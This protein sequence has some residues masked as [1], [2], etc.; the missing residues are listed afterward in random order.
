MNAEAIRKT[1]RDAMVKDCD[2]ICQTSER[3]ADVGGVRGNVT[4]ITATHV[5]I[6]WGTGE[7]CIPLGAIVR[8]ELVQP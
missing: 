1:L 4:R 8:A 2:V 7:S 5:V 6:S 3:G